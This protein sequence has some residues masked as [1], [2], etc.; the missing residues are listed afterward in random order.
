[1]PLSPPRLPAPGVPNR[2]KN[3]LDQ[4]KT[5]LQPSP[6]VLQDARLRGEAVL[7]TFQQSPLKD[8][9]V[10][11]AMQD[12]IKDLLTRGDDPE[13]LVR[14]L[15]EKAER[16]LASR[17]HVVRFL[18]DAVNFVRAKDKQ[19]RLRTDVLR[20][21]RTRQLTSAEASERLTSVF[22]TPFPFLVWAE[23]YLG[24]MTIGVALQ[25]EGGLAVGVGAVEGLSGL[26]HHC[27]CHSMG[28]SIATGAVAEVDL[29]VQISA[30]SGKPTAG[31][32]VSVEVSVGGGYSG[33]LGVTAAFKPTLRRPTL[34]DNRLV[35]YEFKG[36]AVSLGVGGGFDIGVSVGVTQS[37]MLFGTAS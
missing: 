36:I 12:Y 37:T 24:P 17:Q 9:P 22:K 3:T 21:A 5:T 32:D 23:R 34:E 15:K 4:L 26:R 8:E 11:R 29:G 18:G 35:E 27:L 16:E 28:G 10:V 33:T 13:A 14:E 2:A 25:A 7:R 31:R 20:P 6:A 1:M 30:S 19:L